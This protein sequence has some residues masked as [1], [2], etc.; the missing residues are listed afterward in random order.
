MAK[1]ANADSVPRDG[2]GKADRL[3]HQPLDAC[4]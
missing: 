3:A 1:Q 4:P 2:C